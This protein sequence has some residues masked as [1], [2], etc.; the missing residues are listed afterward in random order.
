MSSEVFRLDGTR[1]TRIRA[2]VGRLGFASH[3]LASSALSAALVASFG[4]AQVSQAEEP[5]SEPGAATAPA[6]D[7]VADSDGTS[8]DGTNSD[9]AAPAR[10]KKSG[11]GIEEITITA[12]KREESLQDTPLSVSAFSATDLID[13]GV[14][15][16]DDIGRLAPNLSFESSAGEQSSA[17]LTIRG[18][19]NGDPIATRDP[20]VGIYVDGVYL[21]RAQ[22]GL[23]GL[24][25][26]E[27]VE[28]LRGPQGTLFGRNTVGGA[29]SIVTKKPSD[30]F[31]AAARI[32]IGN[33]NLFES[34]TMVNIPLI[35]E[36][37]AMRVS[38]QTTSRD[39]YS[40]N[41]LNGQ[42]TD[43]RRLLGARV[44]LRLNPTDNVEVLLTG[45]QTRSHQAGRGAECRATPENLPIAPLIQGFNAAGLFAGVDP[46][47]VFTPQENCIANEAD[48][49]ELDFTSPVKSKDN[50]DTFGLTSAITWDLDA[51]TFK[52]TTAWR[53]QEVESNQDFTFASR[54][55]PLPTNLAL[56]FF[57]DGLVGNVIN[58]KSQFDQVSQEL[59]ISGIGLDGRLQWT[60][61]V[62]GFYEK[63]T[64]GLSR[65]NVGRN[66]CDFLT[67]LGDVGVGLAAATAMDVCGGSSLQIL[68]RLTTFAL[69][70]YG[71]ASYDLT[72]RLHLTAGLRYSAERKDF[73][74]KQ[75]NF[76]RGNGAAGPADTVDV[77]Q[78]FGT[79]SERFG[80]W[81]PLLTLAFD[82]SEESMIYATYSRG[83]KSGGFNGR[84]NANV[85]ASLLPFEQEILDNYEIGLKASWLDNR[86]IT[87][88][89]M[90]YGIYDDIQQTILSSSPMGDFASRVA[91]A[92]EAVIR[93]AEVELRAVPVP[94]LDLS[95]GLG[96]TDAEYR[97]FDDVV[98]GTMP[99]ETIPINRRNEEFFNTPSFSAT[100][101]ASYTLFD[102]GPLGD[103]TTRVNWYHQDEVNFGPASDTLEVGKYGLLG[104]QLTMA[105]PDGVTEISIFGEN[106]LDRRY[107]NSGINF[108]RGFA[109]S[110]AYFGA[111]RMY[112]IEIRRSF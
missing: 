75:R 88:I 37:A 105:L 95:V 64:P 84:P 50:L 51:F 10:R 38:F 13:A 74:A 67:Q 57:D 5:A 23:L 11:A 69:A 90:F 44:A 2:G 55:T 108:E 83:F 65:Q 80:K 29:V 93:G 40:K 28:V 111:P 43:D 104:G 97:E 63:S 34:R 1:S 106:L 72:E 33:F 85:P 73:S 110:F 14:A 53:R 47:G 19:G 16:A 99:G 61:G 17:R 100:L 12:R 60:A 22:G 77:L 45:E 46:G 101:S 89:S 76:F 30:E 62:F 3:R 98:E 68:P 81:T 9:G 112:G 49:E 78:N 32:R 96:F 71:Q 52:S 8:S 92:G 59:N 86:L 66:F 41:R 109:S 42:E 94:G 107:V 91:N 4:W 70:G 58:D 15:R 36:R 18:V 102:L 39:G 35:P 54:V 20:G 25:D 21:A 24:V 103:V 26:I 7:S 82:T 87:N 31:E 56:P 6:L 27:R 48:D 79:T